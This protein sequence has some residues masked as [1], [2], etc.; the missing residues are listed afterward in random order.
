MKHK[1]ETKLERI[2]RKRA[3]FHMQV[4]RTIAPY[5]GIALQALTLFLI[6]NH[7]SMVRPDEGEKVLADFNKPNR[8]VIMGTF[9]SKSDLDR[10]TKYAQILEDD[11]CSR[12]ECSNG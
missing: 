11:F 4:A 7:A 8:R 2:A 5:V 9:S 1:P 12:N 10:K 3:E 6:L